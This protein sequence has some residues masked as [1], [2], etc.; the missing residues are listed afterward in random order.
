M[1]AS[2]EKMNELIKRIVDTAHPLRIV[3]FGSAARG[4]ATTDSDIDVLVVVPD[5]THRRKTAQ[6]IYLH[7]IGFGI[8]VDVVVA[9]PS[10]LQKYGNSP[11]LI[12]REIMKE[13]IELYAA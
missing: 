7:L 1:F 9:T 6:Q 2:E 13:G 5:G 11:G 3:L 10:D 8:A 12:Y 4:E